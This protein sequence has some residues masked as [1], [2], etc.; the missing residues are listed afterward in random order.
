MS[1]FHIALTDEQQ[2]VLSDPAYARRTVAETWAEWKESDPM[3]GEAVI[4]ADVRALCEIIWALAARV[5]SLQGFKRSVEEALN[6]G[7]GSY[8]P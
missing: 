3:I 2:R 1:E 8:R 4:N 5:E 6:M 7:D